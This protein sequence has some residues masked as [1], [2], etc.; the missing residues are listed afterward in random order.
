MSTGSGIRPSPIA[1]AWYE[2]DKGALTRIVDGYISAARLPELPAEVLAVIAPHA[3]YRYSGPVAG[4]AFAA[5]KDSAPDVVAVLSPMH[6][7]YPY[8][9]LSSAHTC[10]ATPLGEIPINHQLLT[11]LDQNLKRR[12]GYGL[13]EVANDP[14][15]SLEIELP[16]LQ[17]AIKTSF[18]LLPVMLR[19][20]TR[21]SARQLG[22]ALAEILSGKKVLLVASTDLSHFHTQAAANLLDK[23]MLAKVEAFSPDGIFDLEESG[24]GEACGL[25]ALAAVLWAAKAM[26]ADMVRVLNHATSGDVTGDYQR[27]VGYGAAVVFKTRSAPSIPSAES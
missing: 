20:Q 23:A 22:E 6:H 1:G 8:P 26:G 25:G 5:V 16:F 18:S 24:A 15:H 7:L 13:V 4:Y 21:A 19:Q 11:E 14:E 3:G 12:L 9:F 2:G 10:Y 17:R 27:V